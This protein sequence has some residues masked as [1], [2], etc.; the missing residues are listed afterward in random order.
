MLDALRVAKTAN[1][2]N[3]KRPLSN[4]AVDELFRQ[5][6]AGQPSASQNIFYH[7]RVRAGASHWS[8]ICFT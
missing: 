4:A 6:R 5:I 1:F 3:Q 2:P 7:R 8:G